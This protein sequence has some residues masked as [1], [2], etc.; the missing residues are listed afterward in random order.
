MKYFRFDAL[1]NWIEAH[2][3]WMKGILYSSEYIKKPINIEFG[4]RQ[5]S[6]LYNL[7]NVWAD[8]FCMTCSKSLKE[9]IGLSPQTLRNTL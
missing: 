4:L 3:N 9:W 5:L 1:I 7:E 8:P 2:N 6:Y